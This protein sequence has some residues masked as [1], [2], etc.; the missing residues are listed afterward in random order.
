MELL[1]RAS[2]VAAGVYAWD[3]AVAHLR[4]ALDVLERADGPLAERARVAE[5]LG[6]RVYRAGVDFEEGIGRLEGALADYLA[7]GDVQGAARVHSRLGMHLTTYPTTLDVPAA[8]AHYQAAEAVLAPGPARRSLGY[9]YVG[10]AMAAV[11]GLQTGRLEVASRQALELA[12]HLGDG[13]LASWADYQRAWW[14]FN[15]G[16]LAESLSLHERVRDTAVRLDDVRMGA[17]AAFGRALLSGTYL[18]D[19]RTAEAWCAWALALPRVEAFPRQRDNLLDQLG[20]AKGSTGELADARRIAEGLD[21]GTVLERML[22]YWS[23]DWEQAEATWAAAK[24]RDE[25]AGDRLDAAL[26]AYWLGR[27]RRLLGATGAA[28]AAFTESL[29]VTLEGPQVPAEAMPRAE[30][31]MLDTENG[32]LEAGTPRQAGATW[33]AP[34]ALTPESST[35]ASSSR[36]PSWAAPCQCGSGSVTTAP[37]PSATDL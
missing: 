3:D 17:W 6:D 33:S 21:L 32:R 36:P 24:G 10:M 25:R 22:L 16:R 15:R 13:R 23:G 20:Q 19:P 29:M 31:A 18:A 4:A 8:L 2:E 27:V 30:L 11:F 1:L 9:L 12:E 26:N 5:R 7:V 14:A 37:P 34:S 35:E 28:E